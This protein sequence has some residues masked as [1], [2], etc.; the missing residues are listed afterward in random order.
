MIFS[1]L[2]ADNVRLLCFASAP[3]YSMFIRIAWLGFTLFLCVSNG[4]EYSSSDCLSL[5]YAS[6]SQLNNAWVSFSNGKLLESLARI[7]PF[8]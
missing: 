1:R 8:L 2:C 4:F 7:V 3:R 6:F 5:S